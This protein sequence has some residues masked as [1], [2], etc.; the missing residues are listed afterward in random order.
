MRFDD[1]EFLMANYDNSMRSMAQ[2]FTG[3][4]FQFGNI[5]L[6]T[7]TPTLSQSRRGR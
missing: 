1:H 6:F 3:Y 4:G 7:L 5:R 2:G